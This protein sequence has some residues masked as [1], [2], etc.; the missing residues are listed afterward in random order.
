MYLVLNGRAVTPPPKPALCPQKKALTDLFIAAVRDLME[1]HA[2]EIEAIQEGTSLDRYEVALDVARSKRYS[3]KQA[4][5][6]H[7][8]VHGC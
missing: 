2:A 3:A 1:L 4:L 8:Q 7:A 5:M 6:L